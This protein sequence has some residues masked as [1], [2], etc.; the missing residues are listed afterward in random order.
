MPASGRGNTIV[1]GK[2]TLS[3]EIE[4]MDSIVKHLDTVLK[5]HGYPEK[6]KEYKAEDVKE[7]EKKLKEMMD[8][9]TEDSQPLFTANR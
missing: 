9:G 3:S 5:A 7:A 6:D 2:V 1:F 4:S 8:L